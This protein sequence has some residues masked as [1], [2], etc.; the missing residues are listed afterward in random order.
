MVM[1]GVLTRP[2]VRLREGIAYWP[3]PDEFVITEQHSIDDVLRH[4]IGECGGDKAEL[5]AILETIPAAD[6]SPTPE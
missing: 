6:P 3:G 4:L 1:A 2:L 5:L